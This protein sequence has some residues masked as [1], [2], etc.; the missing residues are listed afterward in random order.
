MKR[1]LTADT[2]PLDDGKVHPPAMMLK[3]ECGELLS[4]F[5]G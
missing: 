1:I 2:G 4:T 3:M 5:A